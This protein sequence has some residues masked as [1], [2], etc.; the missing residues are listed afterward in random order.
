MEGFTK[1]FKKLISCLQKISEKIV[2]QDL[3]GIQKPLTRKYLHK[4]LAGLIIHAMWTVRYENKKQ[5][6]VRKSVTK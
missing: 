2:Y 1:V 5:E 4:S 6:I 3:G